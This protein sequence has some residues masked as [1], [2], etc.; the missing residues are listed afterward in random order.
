[1]YACAVFFKQKQC[2]FEKGAEIGSEC[3]RVVR[4]SSLYA[5]GGTSSLANS[6]LQLLGTTLTTKK[7]ARTNTSPP[8]S[9]SLSLYVDL[10]HTKLLLSR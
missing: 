2:G 5:G 6:L 3:N 8:Y 9:H 10:T 4:S 7:E 1:M